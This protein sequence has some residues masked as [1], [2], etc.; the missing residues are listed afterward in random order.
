[1]H[2][3]VCPSFSCLLS[4]ENVDLVVHHFEDHPTKQLSDHPV[5]VIAKVF[6]VHCY[7]S[8]SLVQIL[9]SE[10]SMEWWK[11]KSVNK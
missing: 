10:P 5:N 7:V 6:N 8:I 9:S 4:L 1:M 2:W 11:S 3:F